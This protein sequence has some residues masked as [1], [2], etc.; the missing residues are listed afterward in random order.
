VRINDLLQAQFDMAHNVLTRC[1]DDCDAAALHY[2]HP[3]GTIGSIASNYAHIVFAEDR[4]IGLVARDSST[5]YASQGWADRLGVTMPDF[6]YQ[7]FE[8]SLGVKMD[9]AR[10][11]EYFAAVQ[12]VTKECLGSVT[13]EGLDRVVPGPAGDASVGRWLDVVLYH[14]AQHTGEIAALKGVQG[15]KGLPF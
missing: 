9:A 1:V 2:V 6:A 15:L 7:T 5:V 8:W 12:A 3:G 14:I 10:F 11:G 4:I 13:E